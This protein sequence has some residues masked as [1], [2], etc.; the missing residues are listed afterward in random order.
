MKKWTFILIVIAVLWMCVILILSSRQSNETTIDSH[1]IVIAV[2]HILHADFDEWSQEE[3]DAYVAKMNYPIRK[4]AH[5]TEYT[6]LGMLLCIVGIAIEG[7]P[8]PYVWMLPWIIATFY[9]VTDEVHQLFVVGRDGK[10]T[11]VLIDS[12]GILSGTM[13]VYGISLLIVR[14]HK[15]LLS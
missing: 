14:I 2:G 3:I 6:I 1:K 7:K 9:A 11:D 4:L 15:S 12:I 10:I 8:R 5:L 13:I